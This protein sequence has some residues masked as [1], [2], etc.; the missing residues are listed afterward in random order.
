MLLRVPKITIQKEASQTGKSWEEVAKKRMKV[1]LTV[2][3]VKAFL[4]ALLLI[5][6][7]LL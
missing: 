3:A 1:D 5:A 6:A 2:T 4:G 7:I